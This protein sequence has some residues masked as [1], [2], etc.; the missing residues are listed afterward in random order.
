VQLR[1]NQLTALG[2]KSA[3]RINRQNWRRD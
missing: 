1:Q 3:V 2:G